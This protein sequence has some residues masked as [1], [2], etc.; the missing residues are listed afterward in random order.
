MVEDYFFEN[1][2]DID[3]INQ[4]YKEAIVSNYTPHIGNLINERNKTDFVF[5]KGIE[6]VANVKANKKKTSYLDIIHFISKSKHT[7]RLART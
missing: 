4:Y 1:F 6:F 2:V 7:Y 5:A 3:F